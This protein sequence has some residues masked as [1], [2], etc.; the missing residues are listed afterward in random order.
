MQNGKPNSYVA[1]IVD[2]LLRVEKV[3]LFEENIR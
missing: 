3:Q 2:D 1:I